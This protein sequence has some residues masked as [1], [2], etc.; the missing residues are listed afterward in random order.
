MERVAGEADGGQLRVGDF[1][2]FWIFVFVQLGTH[3][4]A[5][6]GC[7]RGD[8]LDDRAIATQRLAAPIDGD[9]RKEPMLDLVPLCAAE[10]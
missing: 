1:D 5:G 7:R 4:E 2:A 10:T 9:E 8:Q 3:L 6:I